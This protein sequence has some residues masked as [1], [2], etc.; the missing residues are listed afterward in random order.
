M[1]ELGLAALATCIRSLPVVEGNAVYP[2]EV[3][4]A[5]TDRHDGHDG[6][7]GHCLFSICRYHL[8]DVMGL[9]SS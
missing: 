1:V 3:A 4:A 6:D 5:G 8:P 2:L 7:G 9:S